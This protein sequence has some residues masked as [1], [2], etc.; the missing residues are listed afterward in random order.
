MFLATSYDP[1]NIYF[2][3]YTIFQKFW[4]GKYFFILIKDIYIV[5]ENSI[6][7][8]CCPLNPKKILVSTKFLS[9][10]FQ[11]NKKCFLTQSQYI[12]MI[13][14]GSC[15]TEDWSNDAENSALPSQE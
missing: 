9:S 6:S 4:V 1:F 3:I 10:C 15:D 13:S 14:E 7:R 8:K 11:H 12:K 5:T 2:I